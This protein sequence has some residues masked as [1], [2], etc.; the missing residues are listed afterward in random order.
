MGKFAVA[1]CDDLSLK[2]FKVEAKDELDA[3]LKVFKTIYHKD[4]VK[5]M[6]SY[7]YTKAL[8]F[9]PEK[10]EETLTWEVLMDYIQLEYPHYLIA[11]RR[12]EGGVD[13]S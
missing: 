11:V 7:N 8:G 1:I 12:C 3:V 13:I 2:L 9:N 5:E 4:L 10:P 6:S